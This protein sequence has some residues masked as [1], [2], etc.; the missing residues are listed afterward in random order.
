MPRKSLRKKAE[1]LLLRTGRL[2][3]ELAAFQRSARA[4]MEPLNESVSEAEIAEMATPQ[5]NIL[6]TLENLLNQDLGDVRRQL[7]E[8][9]GCLRADGVAAV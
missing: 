1:T 5:A 8:L 2:K 9:A 6:G 7:D 4:V 3:R